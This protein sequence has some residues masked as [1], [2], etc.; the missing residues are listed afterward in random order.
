VCLSCNNGL[1]EDERHFL[2]E[3]P[4]FDDLRSPLWAS[5]SALT[6]RPRDNGIGG[7]QSLLGDRLQNLGRGKYFACLK[8]ILTFIRKAMHRRAQLEKQREEKE[9]KRT[10][11][12]KRRT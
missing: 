1:V 12:P 7:L 2:L 8:K 9:D 3:C 10:H 4:V 5:L 6:G 11:R